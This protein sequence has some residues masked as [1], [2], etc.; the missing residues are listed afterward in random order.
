MKL[1]YITEAFPFGKGETFIIPELNNILK[2]DGIDLTIIPL[3]EKNELVNKNA[4][5]FVSKTISK[6]RFSIYYL[7]D[8][9]SFFLRKPKRVLTIVSWL[10]KARSVKVLLRN[11]YSFPKGFWLARTVIDM[12]ADHIHANFAVSS[13][14]IAMVASKLSGIPWS[15][16]AHRY[17][18][19]ENDLLNLKIQQALFARFIS[20]SGILLAQKLSIDIDKENI[21]MLHMGVELPVLLNSSSERLLSGIKTI[22]C[23]AN[24]YPVKGHFYLFEAIAH[25]K[26]YGKSV[27]LLLAGDGE[28]RSSLE[29]LANQL[30]ISDETEFLGHVSNDEL[31]QMYKSKKVDMIILPSVDLG[32][33]LHEGIPVAL[34]EAMSFEVPVIS[35][36]TG[37]ISELLYDD[38]GLL[39]PQK[40]SRALADAIISLIGNPTLM[41]NIGR[42]GRKRIESDF[43]A[44]KSVDMLLSLFDRK[45]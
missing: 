3:L 37:G 35:T 30:H 26:Q 14:S 28:L 18:I 32:G 33:G 38:A 42:N 23:P 11:V 10:L 5:D 8:V 20:E 6:E 2:R 34:I 15:F 1:I 13:A 41:R 12:N 43:N 31:L 19:V 27:R 9:I 40:D 17:D 44:H 24:L 45:R 25:V 7:Y 21:K 16:T 29:N 36:D 39:V 22:L 4:I